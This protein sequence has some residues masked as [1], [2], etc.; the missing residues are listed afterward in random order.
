MTIAAGV[1]ALV[2]V[3]V[4]LGL[5]SVTRCRKWRETGR[6]ASSGTRPTTTVREIMTVAPRTAA[7]CVTL[8][9]GL[10]ATMARSGRE[11][12]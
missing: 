6:R 2:G 11:D 5:V 3:L 12:R 10:R 9:S 1:G 4:G 8:R 7:W